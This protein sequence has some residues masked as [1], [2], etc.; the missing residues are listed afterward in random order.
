MPEIR[1]VK[2]EK[3]ATHPEK[4]V[5]VN[6]L[7]DYLH[8]SSQLIYKLVDAGALTVTRIGRRISIDTESAH[9][10]ERDGWRH[11]EREDGQGRE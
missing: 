11:V 9:Q 3:L 2:I 7:S 4:Y 1:Q 6:E 5:T 8:V 10:L